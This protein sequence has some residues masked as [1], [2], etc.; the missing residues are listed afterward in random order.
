MRKLVTVCASIMNYGSRVLTTLN[1]IIS[2]T[3]PR[4]SLVVASANIL[5]LGQPKGSE[6]KAPLAVI[7]TANG[8]EVLQFASCSDAI[9]ITDTKSLRNVLEATNCNDIMKQLSMPWVL[10]VME[11]LQFEIVR[12]A[13]RKNP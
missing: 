9:M 7:I 4:N 10:G 11:L 8:G 5:Q 12:A 6:E 1:T 13:Q 2:K 3:D